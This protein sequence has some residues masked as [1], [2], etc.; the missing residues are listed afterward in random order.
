MVGREIWIGKF[1]CWNGGNQ[2]SRWLP[3][4]SWVRMNDYESD[5]ITLSQSFVQDGWIQDGRIQDGCLHQD[6]SE[7]NEWSFFVQMVGRE[8]WVSFFVQMVGTILGKSEVSFCEKTKIVESRMARIEDGYHHQVESEWMSE[9]FLCKY[10]QNGWIQDGLEFKMAT[11][12]KLH[13]KEWLWVILNYF[14]SESEWSESV[15]EWIWDKITRCLNPR[16]QCLNS[17]WQNS[18]WFPSSS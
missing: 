11:I 18:R 13:E 6:E 5:W 17:S 4:S 15:F 16:W 2:S 3:S 1:F 9:V 12:I 7:F 14:D 10:V 8:M